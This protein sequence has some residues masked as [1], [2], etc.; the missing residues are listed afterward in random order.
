MTVTPL[1]KVQA[2][3]NLQII[4][5]N[6]AQFTFNVQLPDGTPVDISSGW[7]TQLLIR[8]GNSPNLQF[9][10]YNLGG[11]GTW[12]L[13]ADGTAVLAL[14]FNDSAGALW[15]LN[16]VYSFLASTDS[17]TTFAVAETGTLTQT[18]S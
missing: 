8:A 6:R 18:Q 3:R 12:T 15:T 10:G 13:N 17:F 16:N 11:L 5:K 7:T 4:G 9:A 1:L 2:P 14:D